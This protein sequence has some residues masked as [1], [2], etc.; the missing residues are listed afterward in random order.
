M[1]GTLAGTLIRHLRRMAAPPAAQGL[2]DAQ[3]LQR[4]AAD[5]EET[6]FA[7]LL[8]RH[9][10]LVWSVCRRI[11]VH[12][13]DAEDVFQA[14]F[15]V[16]ARRA[17]SIRKGESVASWLYG[18]AYR[19]AMKARKKTA[20]RQKYEA[21]ARP[22]SGACPTAELMCRELQALLD[23][24]LHRL[25][26]K[27]RAPFVLCCMEGKGRKEAAE[28]LG[29]KEGT[30][31]GRL[32]M[33]RQLLQRRLARRGVSLAI[34]L[35]TA[36]LS[37]TASAAI[38]PTNLMQSTLQAACCCA[39]SGGSAVV[40]ASV[41]ELVQGVS[42][43]MLWN[44]VKLGTLLLLLAGIAGVGIAT[45]RAADPPY[46]TP[47]ARAQTSS[48]KQ[49][50]AGAPKEAADEVLVSGRVLGPDGKPFEGAKVFL[51][52]NAVKTKAEMMVRATTGA[53]G[54]FRFPIREDDRRRQ[55]TLVAMVTNYGPDWME[56]AKLKKGEEATLR[57]VKDDVPVKGRILDL[58]GRPVAN[59]TVHVL[60]LHQTNLDWWLMELKRGRYF[61]PPDIPEALAMQVTTGPDG[62]FQ[63]R[64]LGRERLVYIEIS[65]E[66]IERV[67]CWVMT[68]ARKMPDLP[69]RGEAVYNAVFDHIASPTKPIIGTVREKGTGKPLAGI[70]VR[71]T[72]GWVW[73]NNAKTDEQGRYRIVGAAKQ[74]EY[75]V[76]AAGAPYFAATKQNIPDT[77]GFDPI[78]VDFELERGIEIR[79][80]V[81][82]KTTGEPVKADVTYHAFADNPR[83]K[84][85]SG[86]DEGEVADR[87]GHTEA[88]GSFF[89]VGLPGPG[90][91]TV[92]ADEDD[93]FKPDRP[94]DC[95]KGV[96]YV[97]LAPALVHAWVRINPS[98]KDPK[99]THLEIALEPAKP[100][101][102]RVLD[103][104]GNPLGGC[105]I[106]GLTGSPVMHSYQVNLHENP[107][108]RVRG[109]D[110]GRPRTVVFIH[111][112]KKLSEVR[113]VR[114]DERGPLE[115]R[116]KPLS[117]ATGRIL[118]AD[119]RPRAGLQVVAR[120]IRIGKEDD[121]KLPTLFLLQEGLR[122]H[123]LDPQ[124]TTDADGKF[125]LAGLL[126][127]LQYALVVREGEGR[128][129]VK[130][131]LPP[132]GWTAAASGQTKDLGDLKSKR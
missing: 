35:G 77:P 112:A 28:E 71:M 66:T 41:A 4:F 23:A 26:Q 15:L 104:D 73:I 85:V 128:D 1:T 82:N 51:W 94:A 87:R 20:N 22:R 13:Q 108:F 5:G 114:R 21:Q 130:L 119:G 60:K 8:Q 42:Q 93:F 61:F 118:D 37:E 83:L 48:A 124:G 31:A 97:N 18:V 6:A 123:H 101:P 100:I 75:G 36:A 67:R 121:H 53:D 109:V 96:P 57:L 2:T 125:R 46:L 107:S 40:S 126:P 70:T 111:P 78:T 110:P 81:I 24:E 25:P 12:E 64:G 90:L 14:V 55:G 3:L 131:D 58:E 34:V 95:E 129:P 84:K 89:V 68:R 56:L 117:A 69:K 29:W 10:R 99:S 102:G 115:V 19:I 106:A 30:L 120:V 122:F 127:G 91:L 132:D 59:A 74:R 27:Y 92:L 105:F 33:A 47:T 103:A 50:P 54:R 7:T 72:P 9:G 45:Q 62:R 76:A 113:I 88:D 16:L 52:T 32:G 79:G 17:A 11:L 39:A 80:R 86:L 38:L 98:E 116:L 49:A 43:A 63:L 44:K 65:G